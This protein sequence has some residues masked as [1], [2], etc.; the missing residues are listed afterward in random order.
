[1][2]KNVVKGILLIA[3]LFVTSVGLSQDQ[4]KIEKIKFGYITIDGVQWEKDVVIDNGKVRKRKK[5]P[6]KEFKAQYGH[7]P[8]TEFE[9]IPWDCEEL[10]IGKGMTGNGKLPI[11]D[12]L[13]AEAKKRG[14][15]LIIKPTREAIEYYKKNYHDKMNVIIHTTC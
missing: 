2:M 12:G 14:V 3:T 7:T 13:K 15:K 9:D 4:P 5:G 6:S 1:M 11:T 10:L 8:L